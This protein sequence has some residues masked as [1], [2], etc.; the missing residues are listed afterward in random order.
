LVFRNPKK[1]IHAK[2]KIVLVSEIVFTE[3]N[4]LPDDFAEILQPEGI[5]HLS[6]KQESSAQSPFIG[7]ELSEWLKSNSDAYLLYMDKDSVCYGS[8]LLQYVFIDDKLVKVQSM[9]VKE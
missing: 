7:M 1:V 5:S 2:E 6:L 9:L 3:L 8:S 4:Y